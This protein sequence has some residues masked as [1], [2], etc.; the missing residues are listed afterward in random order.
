M[1]TLYYFECTFNERILFMN[2]QNVQPEYG[3]RVGQESFNSKSSDL[4]H[5]NMG[6]QVQFK[7]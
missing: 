3:L 7:F 1:N 6:C 4:A 5:K 2:F